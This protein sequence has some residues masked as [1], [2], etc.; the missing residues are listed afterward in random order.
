MSVHTA[1]Q[2]LE[3]VGPGRTSLEVEVAISYTFVPACPETGPTYACGGT[4]AEPASVEDIDFEVY[5]I[6][7]KRATRGPKLDVPAWLE[8]FILDSIDES[9]LIENACEEL[10]EA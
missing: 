1:S 10:E 4:P 7:F 8:T 9:A 2:Y 3:I 5:G 6:D